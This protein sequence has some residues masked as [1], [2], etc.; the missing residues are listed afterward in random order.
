MANEQTTKPVRPHPHPWSLQ[1]AT[2]AGIPIRLH[3]TFFLGLIY[4]GMLGGHGFNW[5]NVALVIAL[6]VCVALHELGHSLVALHYRIPVADITLYPIGGVASIEKRPA[7]PQ[8]FWIAIAGPAVNVV[9]AAVLWVLF[10]AAPHGQALMTAHPSIPWII[11]MNVWLVVFNAIPAFPMD[12]GRV[13]RSILAMNMPPE[14]ATSIAAGIGQF[15]AIVFAIAAFKFGLVLM[16]IAF[17][18]FV[19]AG[20][21]AQAYRQAALVEGLSASQAM[22]TDIRTLRVGDTLKEAANVLLSSSQHDFPVLHGDIVQGVLTRNGLLR[23]LSEQGPAAYV[24]GVMDRDFASVS[25]DD[26]LSDALLRIQEDQAAVVVLD[27]KQDG[28]L[29]GMISGENVAEF[30]AIRRIDAARNGFAT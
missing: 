27:P 4:F 8:E 15:I 17:F 21:E 2:V 9:I 20:Q 29:L 3:F 13:L 24:A 11:A 18:V 23:G 28:K 10:G 30:F 25:P 19:G 14:R 6:F 12:G 22:M 5:D 26:D 16:L 7:P 1:I